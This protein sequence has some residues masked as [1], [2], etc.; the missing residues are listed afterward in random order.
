MATLSSGAYF[1]RSSFVWILIITLSM[2]YFTWTVFWPQDVP[3]ERLG[4]VG[5]FSKYMVEHHYTLIYRGW[6]VAWAIHIAEALYSL[7][8][9][10]EKGINNKA[11]CGLWFL[12]TFLFGIASLSLLLQYKPPTSRKHH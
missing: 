11:I 6:W 1:R 10:R 5:A 8:V 2:G 12:Q 7:K 3:Y 9:C 4:P